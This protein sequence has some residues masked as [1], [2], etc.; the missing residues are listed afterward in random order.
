M[1]QAFRHFGVRVYAGLEE[2][3]EGIVVVAVDYIQDRGTAANIHCVQGGAVVDQEPYVR[4]LGQGRGLVKRGAAYSVRDID[5]VRI[6]VKLGPKR[7]RGLAK[8]N[9]IDQGKLLLLSLVPVYAWW[10]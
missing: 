9:V 3:V 10:V 1:E 8:Y 4:Q 6:T 2:D 5:G 7:L